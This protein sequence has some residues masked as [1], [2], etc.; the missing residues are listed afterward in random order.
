MSSK[1][2]VTDIIII[3]TTMLFINNNNIPFYLRTLFI[4][5]QTKHNYNFNE[6]D[7]ISGGCK[8]TARSAQ[9]KQKEIQ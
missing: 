2:I 4:K 7:I 9:I 6:Y 8:L 1:L 5:K 3:I